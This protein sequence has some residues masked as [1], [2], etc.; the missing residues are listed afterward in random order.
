MINSASLVPP[1]QPVVIVAQGDLNGYLISTYAKAAAVFGGPESTA[2]F[3]MCTTLNAGKPPVNVAVGAY[4]NIFLINFIDVLF[5]RVSFNFTT[6]VD[7]LITCCDIS[8][9]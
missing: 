9:C 4:Q 3:S 5:V 8:S 1:F 6:S 7:N 2:S